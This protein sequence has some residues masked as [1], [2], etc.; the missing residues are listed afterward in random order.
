MKTR[1]LKTVALFALAASLTHGQDSPPAKIEIKDLKLEAQQT[2]QIQAGNVVDKKWKPKTWLEIAMELAVKLPRDIGGRDGSLAAMEVK[3]YI[4]LNQ[5]TKEGKTVVVTGTVAYK[6][7]P[8]GES[9]TLA[10]IAPSTLKRLLQKDNGGK[11]DVKA[12][13][14]EV[15]VG[16]ALLAG[17]S[18]TGSQW[19][20]DPQTKAPSDK[21]AYEDGGV[22][23]KAKTP[24]APFWGDYDVPAT[25]K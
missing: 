20:L 18:S 19:W 21:L 13:G 12:F 9:H 6:D 11:T 24:F 3:Y 10:F 25:D 22:I 4:A 17:K 7:I 2:P 14:V 16:G 1:I 15:N 5:T 23:S 8:S